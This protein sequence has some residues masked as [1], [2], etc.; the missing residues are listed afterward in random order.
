[1][2]T[3]TGD[4]IPTLL[5]ELPDAPKKLYVRGTLP[6]ESDDVR[7][8]TIVGARRYSAYG[9]E[10]SETLIAGLAGSPI[11]IVSGLALGVD[12]IAHRAS[13][14]AGLTTVAFPGSG[15]SENVLYPS[16]HR[17]LAREII[18]RGG[19]LVSEFEPDFKPT[20]WSF[21]QRNRIM[22]GFS[23]ATLV[24][25]AEERS[26]SLITAK[27]ALEYNR[28][29]FAVPGPIFSPTAGG[30][31]FLLR[32]GATPIRWSADILEALGITRSGGATKKNTD[33]SNCSANEIRI[34]ELLATPLERDTLIRALDIG[35][36]ESN[37]LIAALELKGLVVE[38]MGA[39]YRSL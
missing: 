13:L 6:R 21:H 14:G 17:A 3:I 18:E 37:T 7:F 25:E 5:R 24:I 38:R 33:T 29:V 10:A 35:V 23:H 9:R 34:L 28:D 30:P 1:M 12:G 4:A 36:S 31:N 16:T 19:A 15:L 27:L 32:L 2:Y 20:A 22:A 39:L 8:L 11:F 26:G